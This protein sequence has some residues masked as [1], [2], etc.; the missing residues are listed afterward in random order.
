MCASWCRFASGIC[1]R[2]AHR[3]GLTGIK[4]FLKLV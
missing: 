2:D 3:L 1:L 4:Q